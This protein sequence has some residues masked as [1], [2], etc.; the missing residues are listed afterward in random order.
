MGKRKG[1]QDKEEALLGLRNKDYVYV[2]DT[3]KGIANAFET[4]LPNG[5]VINLATGVETSIRDIAAATC[6][7]AGKDPQEYIEF[8]KDRPG[9]LMRSCGDYSKAK[10]LLDWQPT[11]SFNQG[12]SLTFES[13]AKQSR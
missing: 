12:L 10:R 6:K 11:I 8:V 7:L 2:K 1:K 9:Q 4:S 5:E 3:V 13:Y